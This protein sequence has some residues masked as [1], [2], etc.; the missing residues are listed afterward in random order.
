VSEKSKVSA[1][2]VAVAFGLALLAVTWLSATALAAPRTQSKTRTDELVVRV[3]SYGGVTWGRVRVYYDRGGRL[4]FFHS[5][6]R[7]RCYFYP[8][9]GASLLL[10]ETPR[11]SRQWSFRAWIVRNGGRTLHIHST[12]L[13]L[14]V[15]GHLHNNTQWFRARV[16]ANYVFP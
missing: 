5:C 14:K 2:A 4:V 10:R 1:G 16:K 7:R 13:H 15:L 6:S 11:D 8:V 3:S 9:H 12:T